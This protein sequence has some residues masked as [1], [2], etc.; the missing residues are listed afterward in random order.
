MTTTTRK[1]PVAA[2]TAAL[3]ELRAGLRAMLYERFEEARQ[4]LEAA[5]A[6]ELLDAGD[7]TAIDA[8]AYLSSV[9]WALADV[10]GAQDDSERALALAPERFATNQKAGE[11]A[12][13][14]GDLDT[15]ATYFLTALRASEPGTPDAKAAETSL[16][17][18]RS[19]VA[20]GIRHEARLP[21]MAGWMARLVPRRRKERQPAGGSVTAGLT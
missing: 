20:K 9:R 2:D 11:M 19:R 3:G 15:A 21:H 7:P 5:A 4:H 8:L 18:A 10:A 12:L 6:P 13:R 17:E 1:Q 14:L 16:R